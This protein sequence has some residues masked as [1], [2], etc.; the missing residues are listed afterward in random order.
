MTSVL[1]VQQQALLNAVFGAWDKAAL[2][3]SVT[4]TDTLRVR[5][6]RAYRSNGHALAERALGA[7]FPVIAQLLGEENFGALA[8]AFWHAYPP[9]HGDMGEWGLELATFVAQAPQLVEEPYLADVARTEWALHRAATCADAEIDAASFCLLVDC[10]PSGVTLVCSP[11]MQV[12]QSA[13]PVASIVQAHL[14][15]VPNGPERPA[16]AMAGERLRNGV[17]ETA[18]IWRRAL[19]PMLREAEPGEAALLAAL[20][21]GTSLQA[22]L[23]AAPALDFNA[24]LMPAV[25]S[26]LIAGARKLSS[27]GEKS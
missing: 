17:A 15:H 14:S 5:G 12:V 18:V 7:A 19:K 22:A 20:Q 2:N 8:R 16:L 26:G 13:W 10:A 25:Q 27:H 24:W 11:A 4:Q 23:D 3:G 21:S 6:L 1:A 9:A